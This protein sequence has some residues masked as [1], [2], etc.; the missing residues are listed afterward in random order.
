MAKK[1][2]RLVN[3]N[4][5]ISDAGLDGLRVLEGHTKT[6]KV[7]NKETGEYE[8]TGL[9]GIKQSCIDEVKRYAKEQGYDITEEMS[10]VKMPKD[11]T[12]KTARDF[13]GYYAWR[14]YNFADKCTN[15]K[16]QEINQHRKDVLLSFFHNMSIEK[17]Q[18]NRGSN[19][20]MLDAIEM[21]DSDEAIKRMFMKADGSYGTY[22]NAIDND[23]RGLMNRYMA[24]AQ[25]YYDPYS[26]VISSFK[27]RDEMYRDVYPMPNELDKIIT[28]I[29]NM[30]E[31][32]KKE[33]S[34][35]AVADYDFFGVDNE[36][37]DKQLNEQKQPKEK[38]FLQRLGEIG[39]AAINP[40]YGIVRAA[41]EN[42]VAEQ[43]KNMLNK[44]N[45]VEQ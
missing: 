22:Q 31:I 26:K 36:E 17:L 39:M 11:L 7:L 4:N 23:R 29:N 34:A 43:A 40:M 21:G 45:G 9:Y 13:A 35:D 42:V 27:D 41:A 37:Q 28:G 5:Y 20:S 15:N 24:L 2:L 19:G 6:E 18:K 44:E 25:W 3:Y 30:Q 32:R 8:L 33:R 10:K 38:S 12:E 14:N 1:E 16:F